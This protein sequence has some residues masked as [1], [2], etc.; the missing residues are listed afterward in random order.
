MFTVV[1][2]AESVM[3][4]GRPVHYFATVNNGLNT[5][6]A[7]DQMFPAEKIPNDYRFVMDCYYAYYLG[8]DQP[9]LPESFKLINKPSKS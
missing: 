1:L 2:F 4:D 3:V 8:K 9:Q 5:C 6:K 7:P